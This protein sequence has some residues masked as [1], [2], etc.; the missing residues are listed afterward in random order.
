MNIRTL[1]LDCRLPGAEI[2]ANGET[3]ATAALLPADFTTILT[4]DD[5]VAVKAPPCT[6]GAWFVAFC[7]DYLPAVLFPNG[8]DEFIIGGQSA[9]TV[10][11]AP[12]T[13]V[14]CI[15]LESQWLVFRTA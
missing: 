10:T 4:T 2:S 8:Q 12:Q 1:T 13:A 5:N 6:Q 15:S 11:I 9:G 14:M 7:S 3:E